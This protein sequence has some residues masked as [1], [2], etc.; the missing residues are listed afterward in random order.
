MK[1]AKITAV[2]L[3]A[4]MLVGTAATPSGAQETTDY[5]EWSS[6]S[7][8]K[9]EPWRFNVNLYG[10]LPSAPAEIETAGG[11][12]SD[13]PE[14]LSTILDSLEFAVMAEGE[15]HK[16]PFGVFVS[17]IFYKGEDS[18][19]ITGLRGEKRKVTIDETVWLIKYGVSYDLGVLHLGKS[20]QSLTVTV[21]PYVGGLYFHDPIKL[22]VDPGVA[23]LGLKVR[24]TIEFNTPIIGLNTLWHLTDRWSLR[25]GGNFGGWNV[26]NVESTYE[27]VGDIA[28]HFELWGQHAKA[29]VGYRYLYIDLD[30]GAVE[31]TVTVKGPF[32]G[33]GF[34]F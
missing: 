34:E 12:E 16:G 2:C 10:W 23:G 7:A 29:F 14:S 6:P 32:V 13:L 11:A 33:M 26:D 21:Q 3:A 4:V 15:I 22:K 17:P 5:W 19:N 30:V 24:E 28:Y 1:L 8:V 18:E 25:V 31:L 27:V 9:T 20:P